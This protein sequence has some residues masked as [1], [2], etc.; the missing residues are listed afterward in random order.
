MS[1]LVAID[2]VSEGQ[3][4]LIETLL[5]DALLVDDVAGRVYP[6]SI[7]Q[8]AGGAESVFPAVV[9]VYMPGSA[10]ERVVGSQMLWHRQ[11]WLVKAVSDNAQDIPLVRGR[12]VA[13]LE[14]ATGETVEAVIDECLE[15]GGGVDYEEVN[16]GV[17]YYHG[18]PMYG[19]RVRPKGA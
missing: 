17:R 4:F 16:E 7:P 5:A 14:G 19:L 1:N 6:R 2:A 18:G 9:L 10:P 8:T 11:I 3:Q 15:V 12:I 13:A